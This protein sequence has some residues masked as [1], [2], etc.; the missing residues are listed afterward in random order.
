MEMENLSI[1]CLIPGH[2]PPPSLHTYTHTIQLMQQLLSECD[3]CTLPT[4]TQEG[5]QLCHLVYTNQW[6][7]TALSLCVNTGRLESICHS[8]SPRFPSVTISI[9]PQCELS[10]GGGFLQFFKKFRWLDADWGHWH[11]I[12]HPRRLGNY[13]HR[14]VVECGHNLTPRSMTIKPLKAKASFMSM[15]L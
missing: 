6:R 2:P 4:G 1:S 12:I 3:G 8:L 10:G 7:A 11:V 5:C 15:R 13:T 9:N 14:T